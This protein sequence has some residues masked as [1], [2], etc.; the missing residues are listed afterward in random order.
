[1]VSVSL[2]TIFFINPMRNVQWEE[3]SNSCNWSEEN[4]NYNS[5]K[6]PRLEKL[7]RLKKAGAKFK[8]WRN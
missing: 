1:M 5:L 8:S 3:R 7:Y 6:Q 4:L 2:N